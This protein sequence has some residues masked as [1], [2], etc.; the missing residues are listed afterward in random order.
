MPDA[1]RSVFR[2]QINRLL[3]AKAFPFDQVAADEEARAV[4]AV[5]AVHADQRFC[6]TV[7]IIIIMISIILIIG[8]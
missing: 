5:V 8:C 4:E 3:D 7:I 2:K 6:F 1:R